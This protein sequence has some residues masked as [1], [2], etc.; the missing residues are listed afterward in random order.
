MTHQQTMLIETAYVLI[1]TTSENNQEVL[2]YNI[3]W[4]EQVLS[5]TQDNFE[6]TKVELEDAKETIK[7]KDYKFN[8]YESDHKVT[9]DRLY[10]TINKLEEAEILIKKAKEDCDE[11]RIEAGAQMA[12]GNKKGYELYCANQE[13]EMLRELNSRNIKPYNM[14]NIVVKEQEKNHDTM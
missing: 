5:K 8:A 4:I 2:K 9:V 11:W 10:K 7:S 14:D 3:H 13:I 6:S 12:I 1:K